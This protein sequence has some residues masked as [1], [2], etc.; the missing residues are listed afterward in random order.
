MHSMK[1]LEF[2]CVAVV[3]V[4][5]KVVPHERA[6]VSNDVDKAAHL[7]SVQRERCVL[8]VACTRARDRLYVSHSGTP[9]PFLPR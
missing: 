6:I 2:Q 4:R 5:D 1:G 3:D 8:Y 7:E 9:S